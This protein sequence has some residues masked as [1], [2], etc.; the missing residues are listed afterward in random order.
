MVESQF[1]G[2]KDG[3]GMTVRDLKKRLEE[4]PEDRLDMP[5]SVD[6]VT[7]SGSSRLV[8]VKYGGGAYHLSSAGGEWVNF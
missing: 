1:V 7:G 5:V 6:H 3:N 2:G 4:I 8:S